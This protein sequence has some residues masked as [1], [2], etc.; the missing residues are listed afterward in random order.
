VVATDERLTV[1][2]NSANDMAIVYAPSGAKA[3]LILDVTGYF[4]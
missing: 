4:R 1:P 2:L 3:N